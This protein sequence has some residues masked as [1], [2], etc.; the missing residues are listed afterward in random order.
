[1]LS[2]YLR[3]AKKGDD[4]VVFSRSYFRSWC[5]RISPCGHD[6]LERFE[7]EA[8]GRMESKDTAMIACAKLRQCRTREASQ[9]QRGNFITISPAAFEWRMVGAWNREMQM[10]SGNG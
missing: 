1:M 9:N 8:P 4:V 2:T 5:A 3:C 6:E 10:S 7:K